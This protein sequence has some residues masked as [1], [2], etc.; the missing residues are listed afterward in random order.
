[1]VAEKVI[2]RNRFIIIFVTQAKALN[3]AYVSM[4]TPSRWFSGGKGL[5]QFRSDMLADRSMR[6]IVDYTDNEMLFKNVSIVGGVNYFLWDRDYSG[7]CEITS[8]RGEKVTTMM[9]PLNEY[10]IFIRNN[11][12][13]RLIKEIENSNDVKNGH[14]CLCS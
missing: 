10:D 4:V 6:K 1:M 14:G 9:R 12:S 13:I 2:V 11:E 8:I 5:D 7:D 3:P